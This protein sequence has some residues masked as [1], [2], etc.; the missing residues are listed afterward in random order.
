MVL[1]AWLANPFS[2]CFVA[3]FFRL[4]FQHEASP[5]KLRTGSQNNNRPSKSANRLLSSK[6]SHSQELQKGSVWEGSNP[7][8][9]E[10]LQHVQLFFQTF[11]SEAKK[12]I[13]RNRSSRHPK[14]TKIAKKNTLTS[15]KEQDHEKLVR[16]SIMLKMKSSF[17][18]QCSIYH[19]VK[20]KQRQQQQSHWRHRSPIWHDNA[21]EAAKAHS[22]AS[23]SWEGVASQVSWKPLLLFRPLGRCREITQKNALR[24]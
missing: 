2:H 19:L 16:V 10:H 7:W 1:L 24:T 18:G 15:I 22:Q 5:K 3:L 11:Q 20:T 21:C 6:R 17:P 14:P 4:P 9:W 13:N 12:V 8:N 23:C